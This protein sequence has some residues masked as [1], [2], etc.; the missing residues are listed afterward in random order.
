MS[1]TV[2]V[3][4]PVKDDAAMLRRCLEAL[5]RQTVTPLEVVVVDN[6]STDES[7]AVARAHGA[8]VV[9]EPRPGI[10]AAASTGYDAARGDVIARCDAD[11]V[12]PADWVAR[13]AAGI[14]AGADAVTGSGTFYDLPPVVRRVMTWLYLGT[15]FATVHLALGHPA[16]WGSNMAMRRQ[17][18]LEVRQLVHRDDPE[19]HDDI[20]LA[21]VLGP[22]RRIRHD[23]RLRV[24]VSARCLRGRAQLG[25][26]MRRAVNTLRVGWAAQPP[27][28][29]WQQRLAGSSR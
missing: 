8:R 14:D 7:A 1:L 2:S 19:L 20:D 3:V 5:G 6:G 22:R 12:P 13:V 15:Y 4:I 27:W 10:P 29:R 16:L 9:E 25:R 26:R 23:R 24:G 18:W 28:E 11:S 17:V 21:F